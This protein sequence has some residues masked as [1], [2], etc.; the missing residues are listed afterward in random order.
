LLDLA[1]CRIPADTTGAERS[2]DAGFEI[3][4]DGKR[5]ADGLPADGDDDASE[6]AG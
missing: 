4:V 1:S 2:V 5:K 6:A 3:F